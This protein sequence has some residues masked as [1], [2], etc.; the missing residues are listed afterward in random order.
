MTIRT[1]CLLVGLCASVGAF[2]PLPADEEALPFDPGVVALEF[3]G[4]A[5]G[6]A[7][8]AA[9]LGYLFKP[10]ADTAGSEWR[11]F[12][13]TVISGSIGYPLFCGL[14]AW[15]T[16]AICGQHGRLTSALLGA[17]AATPV[18]LSL[19][20]AGVLIEQSPKISIKSSPIYV[21][22]ALVPAAGAV[23]AYNRSLAGQARAAARF[24]PPSVALAPERTV[25]GRVSAGCRVEVLKLRF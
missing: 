10:V 21:L 20:W 8:C 4:S 7:I 2:E 14:G 24:E 5:V 6:G 18:A 12:G 19:A 11:S 23:Y 16:G 25:D 15:A 9:G 1:L 3:A 13:G 17:F 22:A